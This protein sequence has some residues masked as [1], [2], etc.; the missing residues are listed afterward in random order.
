MSIHKSLK[1]SAGMQRAR[2]VLTRYERMLKLQ[3]DGRWEDGQSVFGLPKV[4]NVVIRV[5]KKKKKKEK[6]EDGDAKK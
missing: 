2:S 4:R 3:D 6:E 1:L 5:G